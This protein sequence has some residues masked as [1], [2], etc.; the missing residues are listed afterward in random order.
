[1]KGIPLPLRKYTI[2]G[3]HPRQVF[4]S[5]FGHTWY[6]RSRGTH[7]TLDVGESLEVDKYDLPKGGCTFGGTYGTFP[8][9]GLMSNALVHACIE[10][11]FLKWH[12]LSESERV[13]NY[14]IE[15]P[16]PV[17]RFD[18][19]VWSLETVAP[20]KV[21]EAIVRYNGPEWVWN[22]IEYPR[23]GIAYVRQEAMTAAVRALL[24]SPVD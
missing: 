3:H 9:A 17:Y 1:M 20:G 18:G 4:S 22:T 6:F 7:W 13:G 15:T 21:T 24:A 5:D 2:Q 8:D 10:K 16:V 11:A 19:E 12:S 14:E 23:T